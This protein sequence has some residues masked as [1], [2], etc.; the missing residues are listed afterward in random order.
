MQ[1]TIILADDHPMF[2]LGLKQ[3]ICR[4]STFEIL[5]EA[6]DGAIALQMIRDERP[7]IAVIDWDMPELN[8]LEV[9]K[10]LR[11]EGLATHVIILTMHNEEYLVNEAV[12]CGVNGFVL[13]D[14]A[15]EDILNALR[16]VRDGRIFLSPAVSHHVVTRNQRRAGIMADKPALKKLTPTERRVLLRVGD[17]MMTKEIALDFSVSPRTIETHRRN[18]CEKLELSGGYSLLQFAMK[19]RDALTE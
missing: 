17:G 11:E 16:S 14:D 8:G 1:T 12:D 10:R 19:H 3:A 7:Q 4:D 6:S 5:G 2:R 15:V 13:K 18:I 9:M